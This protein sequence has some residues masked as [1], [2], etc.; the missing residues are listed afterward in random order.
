VTLAPGPTPLGAAPDRP[1]LN[2]AFQQRPIVSGAAVL[3]SLLLLAGL[4]AGAVFTLTG[5]A[6]AAPS[7]YRDVAKPPEPRGVRAEAAD[8]TTIV[9]T[10]D[11]IQDVDEYRV[12]A[13]DPA[14]PATIGETPVKAPVN[15]HVQSG[16]AP[17][18]EYCFEVTAV[19]DTLSGDPSERVCVTTPLPEPSPTPTP[20]PSPSPSSTE[21]SASTPPPTPTPTEPTPSTPAPTDPGGGTVPAT[22]PEGK[23]ILVVGL[24]P[25]TNLARAEELQKQLVDGGIAEAGVLESKDYGDLEIGTVP[26]QTT[27]PVVI[28]VGV[29]DDPAD[30][31]DC[32][33]V[34]KVELKEGFGLLPACIP[35][36][37]DP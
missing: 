29:E 19:D 26:V 21:P 13:K 18:K 28:Y 22:V 7:A 20:T 2:G 24:E 34:Q 36:Q 8:P 14:E 1:V 15:R 33:D 4:V 5:P 30:L 25:S 23:W 17:G 37:P 32:E 3:M 31:V 12:T 35:A 9:V 10:W 6:D 11:P 16:L 27:Q